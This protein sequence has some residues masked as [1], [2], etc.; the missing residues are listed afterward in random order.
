MCLKIHSSLTAVNPLIKKGQRFMCFITY[1]WKSLV[2]FNEPALVL[3]TRLLTNMCVLF[4]TLA[5]I[6]FVFPG[7]CQGQW[8][9]DT[10]EFRLRSLL[11]SVVSKSGKHLH[12]EL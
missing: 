2:V 1:S 10:T 3:M 11:D 6:P 8:G 4:Y 12:K 7:S 5:L 9:Q